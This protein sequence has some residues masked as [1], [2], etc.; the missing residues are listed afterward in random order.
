MFCSYIR[1][2]SHKCAIVKVGRLE[3]EMLVKLDSVQRTILGQETSREEDSGGA[4]PPRLL[5]PLLPLLQAATPLLIRLGK[6]VETTFDFYY[7]ETCTGCGICEDVCLAERVRLVDDRPVWQK[8]APCHG[9]F[10]CLNFCPQESIQ[11]RS[12]WFLRS[13]TEQNGRYHHPAIKAKDIAAQKTM[14][15]S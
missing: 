2:T 13:Y 7:D 15:M 14:G 9:C 11:V 10:A 6:M 3:S 12:R 5:V 8:A 4:P 1:E